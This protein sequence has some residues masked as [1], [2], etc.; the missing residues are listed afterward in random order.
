MGLLM[1]TTNHGRR[2]AGVFRLGAEAGRTVRAGRRARRRRTPADLAVVTAVLLGTTVLSGCATLDV[3]RPF[4]APEATEAAPAP[5]LTR[6]W[7]IDAEAAFGP[8][9]AVAYE[10]GRVLVSTRDGMVIVL[11][12]AD[13]TREG[14]GDFGDAVEGRVAVSGPL[15]FVP[16]AKGRAGLVGFDAT[17][18][19]R[20]W[21]LREGAHL[22]GPLLMDET[23][24]AGAHDGTVRGLDP[25]FGTV[26]WAARPDT[27]AQIRAAPVAASGLAIVAD[28]E[29]AVRAYD[30]QTGTEV[31]SA[32][33]GAPVYRTPAASG[34]LVV[35]PTT[36][37]RLVA[38]D[39]RSGSIRWVTEADP[40][41][42][43]ATP[44][45]GEDVVY[46][47]ATDGILRALDPA[48]GETRWTHTLD[49]TI[50]VAPLAAGPFV[51][52]GTYR[53]ELVALDASTG[54]QVWS[55]ELGGRIKAGLV[56]AGGTLIVLAEPRFV[57]GFR[58]QGLATR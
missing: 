35:V 48:T 49:G 6:A 30:P 37:G 20:R 56:T 46:A 29:G 42:R 33:A 45:I 36:R 32:S 11:N 21:A 44:S 43:W 41:A 27:V 51:Y 34:D 58:P 52:V 55:E 31:W 15:V 25:T 24:I 14:T 8:D 16:I 5:P 3:D 54:E 10:D 4:V 26:R 2:T 28:T 13:G 38:F 12:A 17:R 18:A 53:R 7:R 57:Y 39:G 22:A 47:G 23:L 19:T 50:S 9:A 40:I 1:R